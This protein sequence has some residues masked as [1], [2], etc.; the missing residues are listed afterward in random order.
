MLLDVVRMAGFRDRTAAGLDLHVLPQPAVLVVIGL[1]D[2]PLSVD[3]AATR[4]PTEPRR[5]S[6]PQ[7]TARPPV[8]HVSRTCASP[9]RMERARAGPQFSSHAG[10]FDRAAGTGI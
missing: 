8:P 3:R 1:G 10:Q 9:A 2:E 6:H 7:L 4:Q 5:D